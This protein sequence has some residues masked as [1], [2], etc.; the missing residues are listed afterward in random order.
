MLLAGLAV[1][2]YQWSAR[3]AAADAQRERE[4]LNSAGQ[5]FASEFN[6]EVSQAVR[7]LQNEANTA[8]R[9]GTPL[10][11]T[12]KL[13]GELYYLNLP[14]KKAHEILALSPEGVF[15]PAALPA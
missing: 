6:R 15:V 14:E 11:G 4:H 13:I 12:P 8:L 3:V 10:T 2:Q 9:A 5:L 7:Y 1:L